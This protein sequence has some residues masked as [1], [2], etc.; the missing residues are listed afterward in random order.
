MSGEF[1]LRAARLNAGLAVRELAR[2]VDVPEQSVRRLELGNGVTPAIAKRIADYF[3][4]QVTDL[5]P[6]PQPD[7]EAAA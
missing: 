1:H 7:R 5:M 2:A 4:V 6:L 3:G